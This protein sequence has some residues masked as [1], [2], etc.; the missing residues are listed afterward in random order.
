MKKLIL[1]ILLLPTLSFAETYF[2][3]LKDIEI[4]DL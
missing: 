2:G 1:L 3:C 4:I